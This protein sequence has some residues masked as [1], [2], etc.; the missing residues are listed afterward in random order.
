MAKFVVINADSGLPIDPR[1][2]HR[3]TSAA[4]PF[5]SQGQ[6]EAFATIMGGSRDGEPVT[7]CT[8][9]HEG[10]AKYQVKEV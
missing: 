3:D 10:E 9:G 2:P 7:R 6:A 8:K 5:D 4:R 1:H